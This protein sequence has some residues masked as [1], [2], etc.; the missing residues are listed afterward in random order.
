MD[1]FQ[2]SPQDVKVLVVDDEAQNAF[3][4]AEIIGEQG[5]QTAVAINGREALEKVASEKPSV[6]LLDVMMPDIDGFE[7]CR[8][9]KSQPKTMFLPVIMITALSASE[10]RRR[11]VEAGADEFITKPPDEQELLTRIRSLARIYYLHQGLVAS[12]RQLRVMVE[13]RTQELDLAT[14]ELQKLLEERVHFSGSLVP[15]PVQHLSPAEGDEDAAVAGADDGVDVEDREAIL[16]FK[17]RLM[18]RLSDSLEGRTDLSRTDEMIAL[19]SQRLASIY[20]A[21]ELRL[22]T[23]ARQKLFGEIVDDILGYGPI[24]PLL[25]DDTVTEIMVNGPDLIYTE[26]K[27]RLSRT[28]FRF[29]DD[30]HVLRIIDRIIRPLGRR[31]DRKYPM[32]DARLPDGSRVNAIIPPCALAGPTITIRK[33][34]KDKLTVEN[35]IEF[36]SMTPQMAQF[37]EACVLSRVNIVVSGGTGSGKTTLLNVLSSFIPPEERI[38]TIEDSAELQLHQ[39]HVVPLEANPADV[40][41]SGEV[42]IRMLVKNSLRMRPDRIVV[43][44]VRGGEALDMLQAMNTGH[45]GSLTTIHANSPRDTLARM[46]TLTLMS[47]M[48]LPLKVVRAQIA[49]AIELIVQQARLRDGSRKVIGISEVQGMEGDTIILSDIFVFQDTGM[50]DGSVTGDLVP[51]GI[52]PKFTEKLEIHGHHLPADVFMTPAQLEQLSPTRRRG[53][54]SGRGG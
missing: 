48:E 32:V 18:S 1:D 29:D 13:E 50:K 2:L 26:H 45:D 28:K 10:H 16:G 7:V 42:T 39:E 20:E 35:L 51:T 14:Q 54:R 24:E 27:G 8:R 46:E 30:E 40:D 43:G 9:I 33:F 11:G 41:G 37:L 4:L 3:L 6:V 36:G 5:Y 25:A 23:A 21:S 31:V 53:G 17:R 38:V 52:R 12:N 22:P 34:G 19:L 15:Q 47:G 49:S 44:E